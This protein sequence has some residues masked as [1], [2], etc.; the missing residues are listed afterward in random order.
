VVWTVADGTPAITFNS[1]V[2][3]GSDSF[4]S[5]GD[6]VMIFG[7]GTA[8]SGMGVNTA[9]IYGNDVAG[10]VELFAIDE[11]GTTAQLSNHP[12][13]VLDNSNLLCLMH[14]GAVS[15]S[16]PY[17]GKTVTI[18]WCAVIL[19]LEALSGKKLM[20]FAD[21]PAGQLRDWDTDQ[22]AIYQGR[23][24]E[25]AAAQA[26]RDEVWAAYQAE[27]DPATRT[28]LLKKHNN[29]TVPPTYGKKKPPKWM[30]DRGAASALP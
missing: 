2:G 29:I 8:P 14:P 3:I 11:G 12:A 22:Q 26:A 16:N 18:D 17:I 10:T 28:E 19:E 5:T 30:A 6:Q 24:N 15:S 1:N 21:L 13:G 7:D 23:E 25:R 20:T 27:T 4:P 9:G